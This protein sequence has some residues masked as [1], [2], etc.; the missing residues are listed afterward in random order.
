MYYPDISMIIDAI[1]S[2]SPLL[3][4]DLIILESTSPVGTTEK[5]FIS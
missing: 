3:K 5:D 4:N 1:N 2:I